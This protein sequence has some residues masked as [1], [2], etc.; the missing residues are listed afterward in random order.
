MLEVSLTGF[1]NISDVHVICKIKGKYPNEPEI[2]KL[3]IEQIILGKKQI[4]KRYVRVI[5]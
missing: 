3:I 1:E 4:P 5:S 2:L